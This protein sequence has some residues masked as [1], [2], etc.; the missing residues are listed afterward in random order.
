MLFCAD[1]LSIL[2]VNYITPRET[3]SPNYKA[4]RCDFA[5]TAHDLQPARSAKVAYFF[6]FNSVFIMWSCFCN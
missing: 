5:C 4:L 6:Y 1:V 3:R 2:N